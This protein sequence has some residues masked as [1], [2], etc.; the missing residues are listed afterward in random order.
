MNR[1]TKL[2]F[3][4]Q[5]FALDPAL[6]SD[7]EMSKDMKKNYDMELLRRSTPNLIHAQFAK[8]APLP[9][10]QGQNPRWRQFKSYAPALT[11][12][13]EGVTPVGK[14]PKLEI[15]EAHTEQ[16]GD[17]TAIS[18]RVNYRPYRIRAYKV[19]WRTGFEYIRHCSEKR[20]DYRNKRIICSKIRR[21]KGNNKSRA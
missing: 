15:I 18:D 19:T 10:G 21:N 12:L 1:N 20:N 16:Y 17:Y 6:T 7:S 9:K 13:Q 3:N 2:A 5:H 11:P 4:L 14:K 8:H